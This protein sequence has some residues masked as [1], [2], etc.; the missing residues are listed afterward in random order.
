MHRPFDTP[1]DQVTEHARPMLRVVRD[2]EDAEIRAVWAAAHEAD[3]VEARLFELLVASEY[4]ATDDF[5]GVIDDAIEDCE[6]RQDEPLP[7]EP[8][9]HLVV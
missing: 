2:D 3:R 7:E 4:M 6:N 8:L 1:S 5:L 9:L